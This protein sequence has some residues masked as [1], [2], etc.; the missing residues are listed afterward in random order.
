ML[1]SFQILYYLKSEETIP[2]TNAVERTPIAIPI[3]LRSGSPSLKA[4]VATIVESAKG[5]KFTIG[6]KMTAS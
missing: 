5:I 4:T 2:V 3:H 1:L 6:K